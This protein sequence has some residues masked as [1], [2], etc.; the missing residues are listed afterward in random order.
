MNRVLIYDKMPLN[1][2]IYME[3]VSL[4]VYVYKIGSCLTVVL[5]VNSVGISFIYEHVDHNFYKPPV[6]I[7]Y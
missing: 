1:T 7:S 3:T 5:V 4:P 2:V 6:T